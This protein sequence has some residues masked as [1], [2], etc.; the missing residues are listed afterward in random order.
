MSMK[1]FTFFDREP[2]VPLKTIK[3]GPQQIIRKLFAPRTQKDLDV[4]IQITDFDYD[5]P[6]LTFGDSQ[7]YIHTFHKESYQGCVSLNG[8]LD[9]GPA[10]SPSQSVERQFSQKVS[11]VK[12]LYKQKTETTDFFILSIGTDVDKI[13]QAPTPQVPHPPPIEKKKTFLRVFLCKNTKKEKQNSGQPSK[14]TLAYEKLSETWLADDDLEVCPFPF[15]F[16]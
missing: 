10:Q 5:C 13:P 12:F 14:Q 6:Y 15:L 7:G 4:K 9:D 3:D 1:S 16:F 8:F 2:I 11:A